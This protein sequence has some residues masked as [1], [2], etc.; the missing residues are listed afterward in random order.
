MHPDHNSG[1][2]Q[3]ILQERFTYVRPK[4][5]L[6]NI[7]GSAKFHVVPS[8]PEPSP[9]KYGPIGFERNGHAASLEFPSLAKRELSGSM[10]FCPVGPAPMK[11]SSPSNAS[12]MKLVRRF[13][14]PTLFCGVAFGLIEVYAN[15]YW[16]APK[17]EI[18]AED[19]EEV[20]L[21]NLNTSV[22]AAGDIQSA[23]N[24][25]VECEIER[26]Y[27]YAAGRAMLS[28]ASTRI[29]KL[30][31]DGSTV[32][33]GDVICELD[34]STYEE[35]VR[36]QKINLEQA[37]AMQHYTEM[38]LEVSRIALEEYRQGSAKRHIQSLRQQM[39]LA[40]SDSA[41][42]TG[43]LSWARKMFDKGYLS[44]SAIRAEELAMQRADIM[45]SRSQIALDTFEK[46]TNPRTEHSF[47]SRMLSQNWL[48][49]YYRKN[50]ESQQK[51]LEKYQTQVA[52]CKV[53][54]P[55]DGI[56]I[57]ANEND[58]DSRVEEGSEVR[59]KQDLF[60]LPN[61]N[62]MQVLAKLS[63]SVVDR[64]RAGMKAKVHVQ[65][66]SGET[67]EGTVEQVAQF[68]IPPSSW[69][70]SVEVKNY[71]CVV[72]LETP[73]DLIRPGM[74]AELEVLT[75]ENQPLLAVSPESVHVEDEKSFCYVVKDDGSI[76]KREVRTRTC[77]ADHIAIDA[78]LQEGES[79]V[80]SAQKLIDRNPPDQ[81]VVLLDQPADIQQLFAQYLAPE[82]ASVTESGTSA[83]GEA[84]KM[85]VADRDISDSVGY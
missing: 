49:T 35:A 64:V 38:D 26:M 74:T 30:I 78:G 41:R 6:S 1:I 23:S 4:F 2:L 28:G 85:E 17:F 13:L 66:L 72:K 44:K 45:M 55:H 82:L 80:R 59:Y 69:R 50:V 61:L 27:V 32:K 43:R 33:K 56:V 11:P 70:S 3:V 46:Y 15:T 77:D 83:N 47:Q 22:N 19:C 12:S 18:P 63:E 73:S 76:E 67:L 29:L 48:L 40:K 16:S 54:A 62:D 34:A 65:S 57:Y 58:G 53:R 52:N 84:S 39:A 14:I 10:R 25:V 81:S 51:Q 9:S 37:L 60:Y 8:G 71:Y 7:S 20:R 42:S 68:P 24:T 21:V 79:I 75:D 36:L 31:P 5:V